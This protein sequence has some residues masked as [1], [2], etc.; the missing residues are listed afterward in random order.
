MNE[1]LGT[2]GTAI[3]FCMLLLMGSIT[4]FILYEGWMAM[5]PDPRDESH[6]YTFNGTLDDEECSGTGRIDYTPE[7]GKYRLY[8]L[9]ISVHSQ[10][11][12]KD[13]RVGLMFDSNNDLDSDIYTLEGTTE[14]DG[15]D[16]KIW[17][18]SEKGIDYRFYVGELCLVHSI[19]LTNDNL[20][21]NGS[22]TG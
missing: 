6:G 15:V 12:S 13:I 3:L 2:K 18:Y 5:N 4:M 9:N 14:K 10:T 22:L 11:S 17:S 21:L 19:T 8:A 1:S 20:E 16:L 7:A